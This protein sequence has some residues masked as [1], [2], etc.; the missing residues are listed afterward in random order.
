MSELFIPADTAFKNN[1]ESVNSG[2]VEH[3][4]NSH[5]HK[6]LNILHETLSRSNQLELSFLEHQAQILKVIAT[7]TGLAEQRTHILT[8]ATPIITRT[9]LEE[10]GS[11]SIAKCFGPEF[12]ILDKRRSPRI[13]NGDLLLIDRVMKIDGERGNLNPPAAITSEYDITPDIWFI[14]D[15]PYSG[16]PL[17]VIMEIALQPCGILSAY[18]GSSLMLPAEVNIFRNLDGNISFISCPDLRGKTVVNHSRLLSSISGAGMMIQEYAFELAVEG[19]TFLTGK[20]SFGYFTQVV[21]EKQTGLDIDENRPAAPE[22][23]LHD[24]EY[25]PLEFH[26]PISGNE[27]HLNLIDKLFYKES[28]GRY[29]CGVIIGEKQLSGKEWFYASHF[30]QDPVMPGSLG[31]EAIIQAMWAFTQYRQPEM[32]FQYP[33]VDFSNSDPLVWK[34]RGQVKPDNQRIHFEVHLKNQ[35]TAD[36]TIQLAGDADFWVDGVRIYAIKNISLMSKKGFA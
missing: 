8:P 19:Q 24:E 3:S 11:G 5:I 7:E 32:V 14:S 12:E 18:L 15:N 25:R 30:F 23:M 4:G 29:G 20:S 17:A 1:P 21:M 9:Q 31:I 26:K 2:Y 36:T 10:F 6:I 22:D 35:I 16:I 28:G 34:Y 33:L 27:Y 13:P